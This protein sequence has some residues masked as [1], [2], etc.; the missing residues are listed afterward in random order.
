MNKL[1]LNYENQYVLVTGGTRGIGKV[2]ADLFRQ[3]G[4]KVI[5]TGT[6]VESPSILKDELGDDFFYVQADFSSKIGINSFLTHLDRFKR[7]DVCVNNAGINRLSV[8]E[9]VNEDDYEIMLSINLNAPFRICQYMA[10]RMRVQGYG[11]IVNIASIWSSITK[12]KRSVY[13]ISKNAVIGLTKTMAVEMAPFGI[14]VNAVSPGFTM[15][16]LTKSTLSEEEMVTLSAKVPIQRFANA[17]EISN[18][19]L[20]L[21]S[22]ENSYMT[23]QN[24]IVDGGFTNV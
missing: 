6:S 16:E 2:T 23:G 10:S 17:V 22:K 3:H 11:R 18:V 24:I 4:A 14:T 13:T 21:C 5:I 8:L 1:N 15:T 7:I 19:I 9:D 20:F 12:S